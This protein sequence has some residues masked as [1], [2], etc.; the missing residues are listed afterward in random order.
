MAFFIAFKFLLNCYESSIRGQRR[1]GIC[2][3]LANMKIFISLKV[4]RGDAER[5]AIIVHLRDAICTAGHIP[6]VATQEIA[7]AELAAPQDF[8][9][10]VREHLADTDLLI[11]IYHPEL[12]GGLIEVGMAFEH[13]IPIWLCHKPDERVSS[14]MLGS[15]DTIIVYK[16]INDLQNK[17]AEELAF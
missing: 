2:D 6:F 15:S 7:R 10:F 17:I 12:R 13:R 3:K 5:E 8:M 9:P 14:S 11:V 16:G 1:Q 4:P